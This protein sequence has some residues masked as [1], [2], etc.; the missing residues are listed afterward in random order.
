MNYQEAVRQ[1][2][3]GRVLPVY[4]LHGEEVY[5]AREIEAA[6]I[7]TALSPA[8]RETN[9]IIFDGDPAPA[10]LTA[11]VET[12]PFLGG[13]NVVV[14]RETALFRAGRKNTD[15]GDVGDRDAERILRL[16]LN[17]PEYTLLIFQTTEKADKRRKLFKA[18]EERGA[19]VELAP[20]KVKELRGWVV[21]KLAAAGKKIAPD[22]LEHLLAAVSMM[23]QVSLGFLAGELAKLALYTENRTVITRQDLAEVLSAVPEVSVFALVDAITQKQV[24]KA[25][26]LLSDQ[27]AI[28]EHPVRLVALLARQVR[29]LWQAKEL[30]EKGLGAREIAEKLGIH[31]FVGEKLARQSRQFPVG[32]LKEAA[33]ALAAADRAFKSGRAGAFSLDKI[34]IDL[35]R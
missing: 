16:V 3:S 10:E 34:I 15:E 31:P 5:L 33:V 6:I 2:R 30:T 23:P 17:L 8:E 13:K 1:I 28:G 25:L 19:A 22:A 12:A 4:L 9:L 26:S 7:N 14:V 32:R 27:L 24:S 29:M 21:D 35:C 11:V 20:L 18:V